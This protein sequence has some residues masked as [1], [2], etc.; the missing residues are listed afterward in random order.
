MSDCSCTQHRFEYPL[1]SLQSCLVVTWLVPCGTAAV[2]VQVM[3]TPYNHGWYYHYHSYG[4]TSFCSVSLTTSV[5]HEY[6]HDF[7]KDTERSASL[8]IIIT[9]LHQ[10]YLCTSKK[11]KTDF[12]NTT[13][14]LHYLRKK[15]KNFKN[16][17]VLAHR[18]LQTPA[19]HFWTSGTALWR[20]WDSLGVTTKCP[21][22]SVTGACR[23]ELAAGMVLEHNAG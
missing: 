10:T 13:Y 21:S 18:Y 12:T 4:D 14:F 7:Y 19:C 3:C 17:P 11:N 6:W 23:Q 20:R 1:K 9:Y 15:K 8:V 2:S 22:T 16:L 5:W